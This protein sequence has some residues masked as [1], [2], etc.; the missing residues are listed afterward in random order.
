MHPV[1]GEVK[2]MAAAES[3]PS[4]DPVS[5]LLDLLPTVALQETAWDLLFDPLPSSSSTPH[6]HPI[7]RRRVAAQY[8]AKLALSYAQ[9]DTRSSETT[10][11]EA[12]SRANIGTWPELQGYIERRSGHAAIECAV[13]A[14]L[15]LPD[16][17]AT[18][19]LD[20]LNAIKSGWASDWCHRGVG[21]LS[22]LLGSVL[23]LNECDDLYT[24]LRPEPSPQMRLVTAGD[25]ARREE[26]LEGWVEAR[27]LGKCSRCSCSIA[28]R[29]LG[30]P[31]AIVNLKRFK[32]DLASCVGHEASVPVAELLWAA[33]GAVAA[34]YNKAKGQP[35]D[36][37]MEARTLHC[38]FIMLS[39]AGAHEQLQRLLSY[40]S[41]E[42]RSTLGYVC[43]FMLIAYF[44]HYCCYC[45]VL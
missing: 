4:H 6:S 14:Y 27:V 24:A 29:L 23:G 20:M 41:T 16:A 1:S 35:A 45:F 10:V 43:W 38:G 7:L 25:D 31:L 44:Y 33:G 36:D 2:H 37:A 22:I 3:G 17:R 8:K 12:F 26:M 34:N 18:S 11:A 21:E 13:N 5:T 19:L 28:R 9:H 42:V 39:A 30:L 15:K 32:T 40:L